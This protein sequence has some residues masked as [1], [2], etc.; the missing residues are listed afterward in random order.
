MSIPRLLDHVVIAGPDLDA[1]V[2]WFAERTGVTAAPG[3]AHPTGTANALVALTIDGAR[4]PQYVELIGP[5]PDRADEALPSTFGIDGLTAPAVRT[6]AV[7]PD[8]IDATVVGAR[9]RGYDPGDVH[10]LSR[11]KPDGELLEWRLTRGENRR[12]DV[13]F[14]IDWGTT[15]QPGLSGIPAIELVSFERV[16]PDPAPLRATLDA[17]GLGDGAARVVEGGSAG[18]RLTLRPALG[19]VVVL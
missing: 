6:Y 16:E 5:D 4:G 13:P 12:L 15:T 8:D 1:L 7:H 10:D 3:G 18:F 14:L 9:R 17:L 2:A 11:R 19:E